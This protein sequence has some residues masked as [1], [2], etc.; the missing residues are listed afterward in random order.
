MNLQFDLGQVDTTEFGVGCKNGAERVFIHVP[1]DAD[2]SHSL[3][4]IA[5]ITWNEL[6]KDGNTPSRY[7][8]SEMHTKGV[9]TYL[10]LSDNLCVSLHDLHSA[11]NLLIDSGVLKNPS[12]IFCYFAR[13]TDRKGNH[14]TALHR[15]TQF[16]GVLKGKGRLIRLFSDSL[17]LINDDV[18]KLDSDFDLL[19]DDANIHTMAPEGLEILADLQ[20][21]LLSAVPTNIK[22]LS[23]GLPSINFGSIET[24][25]ST[26]VRAARLLASIRGRGDAHMIDEALLRQACVANNVSFDECGGK[27][28]VG[29]G[30][31]LGLLE[32]LDRRRYSA[33]LV[34]NSLELYRASGRQQIKQPGESQK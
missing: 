24:Y 27:I 1:V 21:A 32:V 8:P 11:S 12:S 18:F 10:P 17:T 3:I 23:T 5:R 13:F 4:G 34:S 25:A 31:V 33:S 7:E 14:L 19:I 28:V 2:V 16:K 26:H 15:A 22:A 30:H 9:Y 20:R 29:E 6:S